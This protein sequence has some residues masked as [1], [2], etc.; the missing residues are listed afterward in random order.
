M[1]FVVAEAEGDL[2]A[3]EAES[4]HYH[5]HLVVVIG[6]RIAGNLG[7]PRPFPSNK[8]PEEDGLVGVVEA[9]RR[10]RRGRESEEPKVG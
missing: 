6:A 2:V 7:A 1:A 4:S 8:I 9:M 3:V 5:I 10:R